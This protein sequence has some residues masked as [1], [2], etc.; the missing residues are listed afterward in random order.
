MKYY[1][2]LNYIFD[3]MNFFLFNENYVRFGYDFF[4]FLRKWFEKFLKEIKFEI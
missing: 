3:V 1:Y 4:F 2:N